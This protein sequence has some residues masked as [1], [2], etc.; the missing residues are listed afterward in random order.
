MPTNKHCTQGGVSFTGM[1]RSHKRF[2]PSARQPFPPPFLRFH[3]KKS[4][5]RVAVAAFFNTRALC[6]DVLDW[7]QADLDSC[8]FKLATPSHEE[9][10][11]SETFT[12]GM[13]R[14]IYFGGSIFFFLVFL[15]LTYHTE[16]T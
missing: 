1:A 4:T 13:A 11:M 9:A 16:Q 6:S 10:T 15:G 3:S 12:K 8:L 14:N 2:S 5:L 7:H